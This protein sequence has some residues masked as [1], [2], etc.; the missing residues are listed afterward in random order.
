MAFFNVLWILLLC[1]VTVLPFPQ[2]GRSKRILPVFAKKSGGLILPSNA[3]AIRDNIVDTFS[4]QGRIYGYYADV[5]NECQVFHVCLPQ[6]RTAIR[7]SFICPAETVF[8]QETFVCTR[9][10]YSIPCDESEKFYQLN[11]EIGKLEETEGNIDLPEEENIVPG[12]YRPGKKFLR[13]SAKQKSK[14]GRKAS[15]D[16]E[17]SKPSQL[18]FKYSRYNIYNAL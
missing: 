5:E 4:C 13:V 18:R 9:T 6:V 14:A 8:N 11:E 2:E 1:I 17:N 15:L 16:T 7:W 3:T 10:D 12:S